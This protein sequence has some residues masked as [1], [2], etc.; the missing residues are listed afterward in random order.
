MPPLRRKITERKN[1]L[2]ITTCREKDEYIEVIYGRKK[3]TEVNNFVHLN[4]IEEKI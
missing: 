4:G 2:F 1:L 3:Y